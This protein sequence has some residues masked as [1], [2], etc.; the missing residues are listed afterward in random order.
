MQVAYIRLRYF[1]HLGTRGMADAIREGEGLGVDGFSKGEEGI[2]LGVFNLDQK[3]TL[4]FR[5]SA[6]WVRKA[7]KAFKPWERDT[8]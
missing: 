7:I 1:S 8:P 3:K 5:L 2:Q 4:T 6:F